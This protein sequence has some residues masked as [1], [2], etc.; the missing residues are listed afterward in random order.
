MKI[1]RQ[2]HKFITSQTAIKLCLAH[3]LVVSL[4]QSAAFLQTQTALNTSIR[5]PKIYME[6]ELLYSSNE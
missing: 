6:T 1:T 5:L 4:L 2:K 3:L